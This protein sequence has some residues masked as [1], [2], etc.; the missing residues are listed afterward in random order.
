MYRLLLCLLL[1]GVTCC[2]WWKQHEQLRVEGIA[3]PEY[4]LDARAR[5]IEGTV[6]VR[7]AIDPDGKV[8]WAEGSGAHPLLVESAEQNVRRWVFGP[9][10]SVAEFPVHHTISFSFKLEGN[11][12]TIAIDPII[13]TYLPDRVEIRAP[14][15]A[16]DIVG[17]PLQKAEPEKE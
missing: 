14:P 17:E 2:D 5:N 13:T 12:V 9:F 15:L 1:M 4:P 16:P 10:P 6:R 7:I 11:P 3:T 8:R